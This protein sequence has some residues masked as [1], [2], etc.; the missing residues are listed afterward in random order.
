MYRKRDKGHGH[1]P[2]GPLEASAELV[3]TEDKSYNSNI[4]HH[5]H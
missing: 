5:H 2:R 1:N 3:L 4:N